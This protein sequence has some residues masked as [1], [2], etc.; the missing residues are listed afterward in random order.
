MVDYILATENEI[1]VDRMFFRLASVSPDKVGYLPRAPKWIGLVPRF[2]A[3]IYLLSLVLRRAWVAGLGIAVYLVEFLPRWLRAPVSVPIDVL[4]NEAGCVLALSS[5]A[6]D[7]I[8][9]SVLPDLPTI[10]IT[11]PWAPLRQT[12]RGARCI[13][14]FSLLSKQ[15]LWTALC[16]AT[17]AISVM[18]NHR[19][20]SAWV[21]Q[22]YTAFRWFAVRSAI[23]K[24]P[25]QLVMAEHFDRWAVL[26]DSSVRAHNKV[27][28]AD[29]SWR[30]RRLTLIQHGS[31]GAVEGPDANQ[32]LK[33]SLPRRLRSIHELWV[34]DREAE[35]VF[36]QDILSSGTSDVAVSYFSPTIE[37]TQPDDYDGVRVLFVGHPMCERLHRHILQQLQGQCAF[38]AYYK[39]HPAAQMSKESAGAGWISIDGPAQFPTVDL[40]IS[41]PSTLVIEYAGAGVPAAV[42]PLNLD[43]GEAD[44]FVTSVLATL[45]SVSSS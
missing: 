4:G 1:A 40:L 6:A 23:D 35:R 18:A 33:L 10:W 41:Y 21:L 31:V 9:H 8:K 15:D 7:V 45:K 11:M 22:T 2:G 3:V 17:R 34:Y 14:V 26:A 43:V 29:G 13:D 38:R 32:R 19:T 20:T 44:D 30:A 27:Q 25:G 16:D 5:R 39:P 36:K 24:L 28:M 12:P 42:H 37:L